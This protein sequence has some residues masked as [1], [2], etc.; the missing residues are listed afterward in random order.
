M[1]MDKHQAHARI[2][3]NRSN[4]QRARTIHRMVSLM[5]MIR[6]E[7]ATRDEFYDAVALIAA[8]DGHTLYIDGNEWY[9]PQM[10]LQIEGGIL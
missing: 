6:K 3:R 5:Q 7:D 2:L 10:E 4:Y 8:S 1:H 9:A